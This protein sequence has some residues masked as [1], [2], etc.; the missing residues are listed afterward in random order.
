MPISRTFLWTICTFIVANGYAQTHSNDSLSTQKDTAVNERILQEVVIQSLKIQKEVLRS[1]TPTQSVS[2][3]DLQRLNSLSIADA[4]RFFSGV[5]L[6]DYG[7][8]GGI[9]TVDVRSMGVNQT[10]VFYDGIKIGNTQNGQVDLGKFSLENIDK[11]SLYNA[12]QSSIFLPAEGF[13]SG[14]TLYLDSKNPVFKENEKNSVGGGFKTGS[15]GLINPSINWQQ[16]I[17]NRMSSFFSTELLNANGKYKF[18]YTDGQYDTTAVR[19]N[20]FVKSFR[21]ESGLNVRLKDSSLWKIK[22]YYAQSE[23]GLPGAVVANHFEN[24]QKIGNKD[25]F[26]QS[27][28]HKKINS[29]YEFKAHFKYAFMHTRYLD[30]VYPNIA[31]KMDNHYKENNFYISLTNVYQINSWWSVALASDFR[32][33]KLDANLNQFAYPTR[34]TIL[35]ATATK[36][37]FKQ[38]QFQGSLLGTFI[39]EKTQEPLQSNNRQEY[40]PAFAFSWQPFKKTDFNIRAFYKNIFRMPTFNDLYYTLIGNAKLKPEFVEQYNVGVTYSKL[41]TGSYTGL[42][43]ITIDAYQNFVKDKIVALPNSNLFRWSMVNLGKVNIKGIDVAIHNEIL[44]KNVVVKLGINY[45]YQNAIDETVQS[46]NYKS[47]VPYVPKHNGTLIAGLSWKNYLLNYSFVY[48][49]S[50][51]NKPAAIPENY[52]PPWYTHDVAI[53]KK[54]IRK[55]MN[56][57]LQLEIM[58]LANQYYDVILN[59]PMPGRSFRLSYSIQF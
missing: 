33:S 4:L 46:Y 2:G 1:P 22:Y 26:L 24:D 8:I 27:S 52:M 35:I 34:N 17:N 47:R 11:I 55:K 32:R 9:K 42:F 3:A 30:P 45:T 59:Y 16:K 36:I 21:V 29:K 43:S 6:K 18:R 7:G 50:R 31:G 25:Y 15:F 49:G 48:T 58:N 41:Y 5:Q 56:S 54:F 28:F 57:K 51:Y 40:T 53:G 12:Q 14:A 37:Q 13:A 10:A 38:F 19:Q 39:K 23:Q 20:A 44:L